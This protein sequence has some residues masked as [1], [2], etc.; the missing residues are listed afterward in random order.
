MKH[1]TGITVEHSGI[2]KYCTCSML[3]MKLAEPLTKLRS[4]SCAWDSQTVTITDE[5]HQLDD[6]IAVPRL[7][8]TLTIYITILA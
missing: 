7:V 5:L 3:T 4:N 8:T 2:V 6:K 1:C